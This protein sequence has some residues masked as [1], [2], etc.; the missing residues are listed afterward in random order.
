M[1]ATTT[2]PVP[3][4]DAVGSRPFISAEA[5]REI[6][7]LVPATGPA[8]EFVERATETLADAASD[9]ARRVIEA[10]R[11]EFG[12]DEIAIDDDAAVSLS[13]NGAWVQAWLHVHDDAA[14]GEPGE[15]D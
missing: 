6:A 12:D 3:A 15:E 7:A 1:T 8:R 9:R 13:S 2:A 14:P 11:G 10:A 5:L 4:A